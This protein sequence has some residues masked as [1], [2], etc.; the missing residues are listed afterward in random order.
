MDQVTGLR[1]PSWRLTLTG[2]GTL[3]GLLVLDPAGKPSPAVARTGESSSGA[4]EMEAAGFPGS[5]THSRTWSG[6]S[7]GPWPATSS[8][9][10]AGTIRS[11]YGKKVWMNS[12]IAFLMSVKEI[13]L[14]AEEYQ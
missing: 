9:C 4:R 7:A 5:S 13:Q 10:L 14:R 3:P 12:G 2:G 11:H 1:R 6:M 8:L